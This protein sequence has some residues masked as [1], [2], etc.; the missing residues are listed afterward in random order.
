MDLDN[1]GD[2]D[3]VTNNINEYVD[4]HENL[5]GGSHNPNHYLKIKFKGSGQNKFGV[6]AKVIIYTDSLTVLQENYTTRGYLSAVAPNLTIGLGKTNTIDSLVVIWPKRNYQILKDLNINNSLLLEE[7]NSKGDYYRE[8]ML[9]RSKGLL[10]KSTLPIHYKHTD[11]S[12][13]EFTRDPLIPYMNTYQG[14]DISIADVN[15]DGLSDVFIGG[16]KAQ[17]GKLFFQQSDGTFEISEHHIFKDDAISED[18]KNLFFDADNDGDQDLLVISGGNEFVKGEPLQPRLYINNNGKFSKKKNAFEEI[19]L[20]G[21]VVI[22]EDIDND[23]DNDLFIGANSVPHKFGKTP[24]NYI[25]TNDGKG[26]FS[27]IPMD[28]LGLVQDAVF[29]D[30]DKDNKKDLV[31]VGY[32]MPIT[33]L[34]NTEN[35]FVIAENESLLYTNGLWNCLRA[36]DFDKDGDVD[37]FAGNWGLNTRLNASKEEPITLYLNDF[38][39]NKTID[40]V[41]SYF[42]QGKEIPFSTK[43]ELSKQLPY[44]NKKYLSYTAF[45]KADIN[46]IFGASELA[47]SEKKHIYTLATTYF[48]NNGDNTFIPKELPILVQ[49]SS[50]H[51]LY[52]EDFDN[53]GF[54]DVLF[55]G[56]RYDVNTQLGRLDASHGHLLLNYKGNFTLDNSNSFSMEGPC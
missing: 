56:N 39:D 43:E 22:S 15:K 33:I 29:I 45:A 38:D 41:I 24:V 17:S 21:S 25:F 20:N 42:H 26:N 32:W 14:P 48:E 50:V 54:A 47:S 51:S 40:P 23:G 8:Y 7:E 6:G 9:P 53:N 1:D 13:V 3:L 16:A 35:G 2:L 36:V 5:S 52:L 31:V 37:I 27:S 34:L 30:L 12:F 19:E 44:L 18:V 55:G 10:Q 49:S 4:I 28:D 11:N 46:D